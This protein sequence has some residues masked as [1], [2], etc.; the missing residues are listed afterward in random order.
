LFDRAQAADLGGVDRLVVS[1][2]IVYGENLEA[3]ARPELGGSAGGTQPT[4]PDGV[5]L[6]SLTVLSMAASLTSRVRLATNIL[7][8]ALRRAAPLAKQLATLDLL[9][10]G[11]LDLGVGVGWQREEYQVSGLD[12]DARGKQL[13]Q[14]LEVLQLLWREPVA[15]FSSPALSFEKIHMQPKPLQPGGVPIWVSGTV[16][17]AVVNRLGRFGTGWIVW[18]PAAAD[19]IGGVREMKDALETAGFDPSNLEVAANVVVVHQADG[20][21][22]IPAT[23]AQVPPLVEAGITD[24]RVSFATPQ[25]KDQAAEYYSEV[26]A[27]FRKVTA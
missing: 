7:E 22:D 12:F 23:M 10:N 3:Y 24:V 6:D 11:R 5:W 2:H 13:D 9:S 27:A 21:M 14:T 25:G 20:R 16:N 26:V 4:G 1:E 17:K 15:S 18:G 19:P 8:A